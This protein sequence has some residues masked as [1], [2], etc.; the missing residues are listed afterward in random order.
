MKSRMVSW[1]RRRAPI[2]LVSFFLFAGGADSAQGP[3]TIVT[4][5]IVTVAGGGALVGD[6]GPATAALLNGPEAVALDV[7][8]NLYIV[9]ISTSR[10]RRID[11]MTGTITTVAGTGVAGYAGDGGPAANA[12]LN[13]P[14]GVAFDSTGNLYIGDSANNRI[15]KVDA[16]TRIITTVAGGG[17]P[18]D[19]LG[20]GLPATAAQ[21][22]I[23]FGAVFD[24]LGNM[25]VADS[26][27]NRVRKVDA[28]TGIITTF[29]GG[30]TPA[31]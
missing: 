17:A 18:T 9:Q 27:N 16:T 7:F 29:A 12:L 23:P 21:L 2:A 4:H 3:G 20:D 6:G 30:G 15:R 11:A 26:A 1:R 8:G 25:Y 13:T 28:I 24:A 31:V 10:I 22:S 14:R 19:G 5:H